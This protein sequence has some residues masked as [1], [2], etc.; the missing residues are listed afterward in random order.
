MEHI[1]IIGQDEKTS[2]YD[3]SLLHDSIVDICH[4]VGAA[5]GAAKS[6]ANFVLD[7]VHAWLDNKSEVTSHDLRRIAGDHLEQ[8][9]PEAGYLYK[10]YHSIV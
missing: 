8:F 1:H 5:E 10:H 2:L 9:L 7:H 4:S 6:A 3:H